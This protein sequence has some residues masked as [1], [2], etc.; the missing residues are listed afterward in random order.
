MILSLNEIETTMLKAAR[1][2]GMAWGLAEEAAQAARW[3]AV[4]GVGFEAAFLHVLEAAPWR[5]DI[6]FERA[7]FR[8]RDPL[9][10]LCPIRVGACLSDLPD[11]L[12]LRVERVLQPLLLLPF[13]ARLDRPIAVTWN[14]VELRLPDR[15]MAT[16][17]GNAHSAFGGWAET[18]ELTGS[19]AAEM[20]SSAALP[21][22]GGID[23]DV[24]RWLQLRAFEA[25]TY[26]PATQ[27]SRLL[28]AG[29]GAIDNQ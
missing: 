21:S 9:A 10:S 26:V 4:A 15:D 6:V 8:P 18:V 13:A 12:P 25:R 22:A 24:A 20:A 7:T 1:G 16:Q 14:G 19:D 3:L 2:A 28:G 11:I 5:T 23:I 29:A 27:R 17:A